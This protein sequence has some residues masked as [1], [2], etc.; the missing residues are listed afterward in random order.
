MKEYFGTISTF[1]GRILRWAFTGV[2]F[3]WVFFWAISGTPTGLFKFLVVYHVSSQFFMEPVQKSTIFEGALKGMVNALNEPHSQYLDANE[4]KDIM[5]QT[6]STYS[7]VG[8]VLGDRGKG[9]EVIS[10][11]EDSPASKAGVKSGDLISSI[12]GENSE[13]WSLDEVSKHLRGE[14][15][16][17]VTMQ[18]RR[19]TEVIEVLI[20]RERITLPT[21]KE[22]MQTSDIGYIRIT[23]F[24]EHTGADFEAAYKR[25]QEQGMKKLI[26]DLR[27]NPGGLIT[28]ARDVSDY[29]IPQGTLLTIRDRSG[30]LESYD[31]KGLGS[32]LPLV[33]LI[34]KGSA[35]ASEIIAGAVQDLE[36]GTIIGTKSYGKGTV[37]TIIP[38]FGQEGIKITIAKYHTP[39]DR[40]IDGI[41]IEPDIAISLDDKDMESL[42]DKQLEKAIEFLVQK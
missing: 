7:G 22:K 6:E 38:S 37:Q 33:V 12:N 24:A 8:I 26:V 35:S 1:L 30:R 21:V 3:L 17:E 31:S 15:G 29:L 34:D 36:V 16:T 40:V 42:K 9:P 4:L 41:G 2:V 28:A 19:G 10:A 39:K 5:S 32:N 25:L 11:I 27:H 18:L 20:K 23:Q 14:A 13:K